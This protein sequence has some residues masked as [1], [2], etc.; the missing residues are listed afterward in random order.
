MAHDAAVIEEPDAASPDAGVAIELPSELGEV[1]WPA[2][3]ETVRELEASTRGDIE[4]ALALTGTHVRVTGQHEATFF[5]SAS[6]IAIDLEDDA[7]LERVYVDQGVQRVAIRG[8]QIGSIELAPPIDFNAPAPRVT[9]ELW[10]RDVRVEGVRMRA[11]D[12]ALVLRGHR[13]AIVDVDVTAA[14]YSVWVGDTLDVP[15]EDVTLVRSSFASDGPE[16]T[17]R[18]HDVVRAVIVDTRLSNTLKHNVR[19]HGRSDLV[20]VIG[21]VLTGTGAMMGTQPGDALERIWFSRNVL[22]QRRPGSLVVEPTAIAA[23]TAIENTVYSDEFSEVE[24]GY[25]DAPPRW[26]FEGNVI[27]PYREPPVR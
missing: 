14:R 1:V 7:T 9:E 13:L 10:I 12:S 18:M 22:Y 25:S 15:S 19:V 5:V 4:A 11:S 2:P 16:A 26:R 17:V 23:L 8:G 6:D 27:A 20:F 24:Q 21:N 3:P